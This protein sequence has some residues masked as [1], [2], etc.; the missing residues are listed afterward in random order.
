MQNLTIACVGEELTLLP[1]RALFW[2]RQRTLFVA[3]LHLGKDATF[4]AAGIAIPLGVVPKD[5]ARLELLVTT[6][7]AERLIILGDLLHARAG[8][9]ADTQALI[10]AWRERYAA[11]ESV[12]VRGNHDRHAGEPLAEWGMHTVGDEWLLPPFLCRHEPRPLTELMHAAQASYALAGHVHPVFALREAHGAGLRLPCFVFGPQQAI[13]PAFGSFTG[14]ATMP[15]RVDERVF[16]IGP[17]GV[18]AL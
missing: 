12:L 9:T 16:V 14:G 11:L 8:R 15:R 6:A 5:L 13:L 10:T 18:Y 2:P 3:D 4:R 17:G 7:R 1:E